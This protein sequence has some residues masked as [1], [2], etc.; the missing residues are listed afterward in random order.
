[1]PLIDPTDY[2]TGTPPP[3]PWLAVAFVLILGIGLAAL[4]L[5]A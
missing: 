4:G 3:D 1:M 2:D 5:I